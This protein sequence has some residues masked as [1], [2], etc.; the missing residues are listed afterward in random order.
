M[1]PTF[2]AQRTLLQRRPTSQRRSALRGAKEAGWLAAA[3]CALTL[4]LGPAPAAAISEQAWH[5][6]QK[7]VRA[8]LGQVYAGERVEADLSRST[9]KIL[10]FRVIRL[11]P[12]LERREFLGPN[13]KPNDIVVR[14][15]RYLWHY[16]PQRGIVV[17]R[18]APSLQR[19]HRL[20][21]RN[22]ELI[23]KNYLVATRP[24]SEPLFGRWVV[25]VEFFRKHEPERLLRRDWVDYENGLTLR[26]EVFDANARMSHLSY[27][28]SI[29]FRPSLRAKT[30]ELRVPNSTRTQTVEEVS[31]QTPNER[32]RRLRPR[33]SSPRY[34]PPGF[35]LIRARE[36][37]INRKKKLLLEYSDGLNSLMLFQSTFRAT[38][39]SKHPSRAIALNGA[40]AHLYD[41]G[42]VRAL[43]WRSRG[44]YFTL[45][46]NLP[47]EELVRTAGSIP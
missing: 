19:R 32:S 8:E 6:L 23:R 21:Q 4:I 1:L 20:L 46:G 26:T 35:S 37:V 44:I 36:R 16:N 13:R 38:G 39:A 40:E 11:L 30:F 3:A 2:L 10:H 18:K 27:F 33:V 29:N 17:R 31:L 34:L 41:L 14:D 22:L 9:P 47:E 25:L 43:K 24:L 12:N 42:R 15:G 28:A 45:V 5:I 7:M